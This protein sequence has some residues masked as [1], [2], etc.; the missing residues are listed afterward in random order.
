MP[1]EVKFDCITY[2]YKATNQK[3]LYEFLMLKPK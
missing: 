3:L 1:A 2:D